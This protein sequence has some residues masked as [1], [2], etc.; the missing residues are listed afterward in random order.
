MDSSVLT[1]PVKLS[2]QTQAF[3][4]AYCPDD[5]TDADLLEIKDSL[6]HLGKALYLYHLQRTGGHHAR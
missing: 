5:L 4:K 6:Y 3:I 2:P 1:P